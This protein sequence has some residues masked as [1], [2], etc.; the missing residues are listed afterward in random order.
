MNNIVIIGDINPFGLKVGGTGY[1]IL[2]FLNAVNS[3]ENVLLYGYTTANNVN[4]QIKNNIKFRPLL[5]YKEEKKRYRLPQTF[6]FIFKIYENRKEIL[7]M[8]RVFHVQRIDHAIPFLFP[9][10]KGKIVVYF[11]GT[12]SKGYLT[13]Q[14]IKSKLKGCIY[15]ILEHLILPK[16]DKIV[17]VS[18]KDKR[19]YID[20]YPE[21]RNKIVTIPTPIDLDIFKI[22]TDKKA[23]RSKYGLDEKHK[24]ILYAGRFSKVKRID[25]IIKAFVN[26]NQELPGT[27][28][29]LVGQ[30]N[31]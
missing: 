6:K 29:I 21:T 20:K 9:S 12:A 1:Y 8:G 22:K 10:K 15:L 3:N 2:N 13:G 18:G 31:S 5:V 25:L 11:H 28:L 16:A 24:I 26:L 14:G 17:T 19:F 7:S 27:D 4:K 23:L 30:S